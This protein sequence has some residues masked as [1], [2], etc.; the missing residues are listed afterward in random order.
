MANPDPT[1]GG[2]TLQ[3]LLASSGAVPAPGAQTMPTD[4]TTGMTTQTMPD[5]NL[6]SGPKMAPVSSPN[7]NAISNQSDT[8]SL[9]GILS[10]ARSMPAA[11]QMPDALRAQMSQALP[12]K[13]PTLLSTTPAENQAENQV[14]SL[15]LKQPTGLTPA[16]KILGGQLGQGPTVPGS[17][18]GIGV[19]GVKMPSAMQPATPTPDITPPVVTNP[20]T[21]EQ[22]QVGAPGNAPVLPGLGQPTPTMPTLANQSFL[23]RLENA[24]GIRK[25]E[26]IAKGIGGGIAG[27]TGFGGLKN[28]IPILD[29]EGRPISVVKRDAQGNIIPDDKGNPQPVLDKRGNPTYETRPPTAG[30]KGQRIVGAIGHLLG[31]IGSAGVMAT[32]SPEQ[33]SQEI[34]LQKNQTQERLA[35]QQA[36]ANQQYKMGMLGVGQERV[37]A[38][39]KDIESKEAKR[40]SDADV[41]NLKVGRIWNEN[42]GMY[43]DQTPEQRHS[44]PYLDHQSNAWKDNENLINAQTA[45]TNAKRDLDI[46]PDNPI[47]KFKLEEA[48]RRADQADARTEIEMALLRRGIVNHADDEADKQETRNEHSYDI[49]ESLL[50]RT[51]AL[52][53]EQRAQ[54]VGNLLDTLNQNSPQADSLVAPELLSIMAGGM[55]SGLRMNESEIARIVGGKSQLEKLRSWAMSYTTN[56]NATFSLTPTQ[57]VQIHNLIS[58]VN[59]RLTQKEAVI[60]DARQKLVD[61]NSHGAAAPTEHKQVLIDTQR[62]LDAI[63]NPATNSTSSGPA[64]PA[65]PGAPKQ[66]GAGKAGKYS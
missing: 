40:K 6:D 21:P 37:A 5:T 62:Q 59:D 27:A 49:Q 15:A 32:G 29:A 17:S 1:Q 64:P 22:Q 24:A 10:A 35:Q 55:G 48:Q 13:P 26:G 8:D 66:V 7:P 50:N 31:G 54:K 25:A 20:L 44:N 45:L 28:Q 61:A 51:I 34:E 3:Q 30:E 65:K 52:P 39:A 14:R 16:E 36:I 57:R 56:P 11:Q 33:K 23:Q 58:T 2:L 9:A 12:P 38:Y 60:N 46:N 42:L 63:D 18:T 4:L 53:V 19:Y 47:N 41:A 43:T